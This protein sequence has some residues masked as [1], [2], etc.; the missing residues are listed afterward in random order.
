MNANRNP[1]PESVVVF[2]PSR[3][4]DTRGYF[5]ATFHKTQFFELTGCNDEF[6]QDNHSSSVPGVLR[7]LHYQ[8]EPSAQGKLIHV[9][10]GAAFDVAVDIRRSSAT[11]GKWFG[12]VLSAEE[13]T[14]MWIPPGFAHGYLALAGG[15]EVLY[16][17][18][19]FYSPDQERSIRWDDPIIDINWPIDRVD[20][21]VLSAR[22]TTAPALADAEVFS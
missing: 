22:D 19:D 21:V 2:T 3:F 16:K 15:A 4:V 6:V 12:V 18:T 1:F 10:D 9:V 14:Q 11:F 5:A 13:G 17:T 7:G 20:E 8:L